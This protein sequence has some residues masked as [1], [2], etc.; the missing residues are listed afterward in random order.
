LRDGA[1]GRLAGL[2]TQRRSKSDFVGSN[3]SPATIPILV[4]FIRKREIMFKKLWEKIKAW[5]AATAL[6]WI[7]KSWMQVVNII[8]IAIA[9]GQTDSLPWV[10]AITGLWL[11]VL[12]GY[13][14]FWKL[15]GAEKMFK[16]KTT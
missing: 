16:K 10:Q 14:I 2:I 13:Y 9:Y 1:V 12:L 4:I 8:V 15:F 3:P 7:K 5:W 11:F 6:P